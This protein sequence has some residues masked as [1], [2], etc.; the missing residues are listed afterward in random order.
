MTDLSFILQ[1]LL[2]GAIYYE[3]LSNC[4][5]IKQIGSGALIVDQLFSSMP[6]D[7]RWSL[8]NFPDRTV[9]HA[10]MC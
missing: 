4:Y 8:C 9:Y 5:K 10:V 3:Q 2:N 1:C 6:R 7:I